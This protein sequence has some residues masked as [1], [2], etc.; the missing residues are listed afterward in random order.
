MVHCCLILRGHIRDAFKNDKMYLFTK[1]LVELYNVDVYIH[2]WN[3][4]QKSLSWR[5]LLEN[6]TP[7]TENTITDYFKDIPIKKIIIDDDS[8]IE[9]FGRTTGTICRS[10]LPI[11]AWKNMWYG[12][13]QITNAVPKDSFIINTRF[14]YF[15]LHPGVIVDENKLLKS[16]DLTNVNISFAI[17]KPSVGV[18]NFYCGPYGKI[19]S[20]TKDFRYNL[21]TIEHNFKMVGD[22]EKIVFLYANNLSQ[23]AGGVKF[24]NF[25][26]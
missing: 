7:V 15:N 1:K 6:N 13:Y 11:L 12:I 14:D 2:T 20:L 4:V 5:P 24:G 17:N 23:F 21:D 22:Q 25:F 19:Y 10:K 26:R 8:K 3:I 9:I 16:I 18:D